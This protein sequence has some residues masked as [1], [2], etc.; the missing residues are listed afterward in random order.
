MP[1]HLVQH[2]NRDRVTL[3][4]SL[5]QAIRVGLG[6]TTL[7]MARRE[8]ARSL[9]TSAGLESWIGPGTMAALALLI[10]LHRAYGGSVPGKY[11]PYFLIFAVLVQIGLLI[12][13]GRAVWASTR[14]DMASGSLEELLLTGVRP[15]QLLTGKWAGHSLAGIVW[16]VALLPFALIAAACTG[17]PPAVLLPLTLAWAASASVGATVAALLALSGRSGVATGGVGWGIIQ[18]WLLFRFLMPRLGVG[19]GPAWSALV[20]VLQDV[21]PLTLVPAAVGRVHEPWWAKLLFLLGAEAAAITWLL[22]TEHEVALSSR[23]R[24]PEEDAPLLSLRP[25]RAWMTAHRGSIPVTYVRG[26]LFPFEQIHGWRLRISPPV[27][28]L[29]LAPGLMLSLPLAI[30]G[31]EA[32]SVAVLLVP[33]EVALAAMISGLGAAASLAAEREQGRWALLLCAPFTTG[34]IVRAKW[35]A[36]W[37]E[38]WPLWPAAVVHTLVLSATG[39]LPWTAIAPAVLAV[40]VAS[41]VAAAAVMLA[42]TTA[43]SL[44]VAQ[45]RAVLLLL[46]PVIVAAVGSWLLPGLIGLRFISLPQILLAAQSFRP[47]WAS[48]N[49]VLLVLGV[50]T[51]AVPLG[52]WLADWQLRRWPPI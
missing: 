2:R 33:V 36:A 14:R 21:D 22:C 32:H 43:P 7:I 38:T 41:A 26:V 39:A 1:T 13:S 6:E 27:W 51:A 5:R 44:A 9:P 48:L 37:L 12:V 23:S 16:A 29:L 20:R 31:R 15:E 40:P 24:N 25:M 8:L 4:H 34:E 47:G 45:Q 30:L 42:C 17:T 10:P 3:A 19:L 49:L 52:L 18:G 11:P 35:Q 50:Y 46:L 28:L